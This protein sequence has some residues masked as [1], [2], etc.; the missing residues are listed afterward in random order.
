MNNCFVY[1]NVLVLFDERIGWF[2]Y[3]NGNKFTFEDKETLKSFINKK[4]IQD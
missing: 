1:R 3:D 2:F 4:S